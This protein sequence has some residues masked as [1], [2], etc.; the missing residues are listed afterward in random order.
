VCED[1]V[2][3]ALKNKKWNGM[4]KMIIEDKVE[5]G[6]G[7]FGFNMQRMEAINFLVPTGSLK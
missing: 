5:F 6:I 2:Y 7:A 1:G 3:G 4:I